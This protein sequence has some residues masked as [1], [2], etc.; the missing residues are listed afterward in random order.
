MSRIVLDLSHFITK[1]EV[2]NLNKLVDKVRNCGNDHLSLITT[3]FTNLDLGLIK[4]IIR[5]T[6]CITANETLE[7]VEQFRGELE[8][9]TYGDKTND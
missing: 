1:Q 2:I 7:F 8:L 4:R 3:E 9:N 6:H 5:E